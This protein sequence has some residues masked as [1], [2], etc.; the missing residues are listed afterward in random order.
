MGE[1]K[2]HI[3][4]VLGPVAERYNLSLDAFGEM[5]GDAKKAYG[6]LVLSDAYETGLEPAPITPTTGSGP[7]ELLS[8]TIRNTIATSSRKAYQGKDA[9]V[10]PSISLGTFKYTSSSH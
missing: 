9:V 5:K 10:T 2:D 7:W 3:T 1:L 8:G 4:S 6:Q